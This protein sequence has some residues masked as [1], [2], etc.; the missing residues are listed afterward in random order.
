MAPVQN[1]P[2]RPNVSRMLLN[3]P[4]N[5]LISLGLQLSENLAGKMVITADG[6]TAFALSESGFLTLPLATIFQ[7]P[8][9]M[10]DTPTV[11]LANDQCG[12]VGGARAA[13]P[14][15]NIGRGRLTASA[16]LLQVPVNQ[17]GGLGAFPVPGGGPGGTIVV[18]L[19]PIVPGAGAP[20][21]VVPAPGGNGNAAVLQT[22]PQVQTQIT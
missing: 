10:P 17:V 4:D 14:V 21:G 22:A 20:P 13:V 8:I 1:P 18:V 7:S 19:P 16:Q 5:L 3:D 15:N 9:A 6:G 11:L 2:A 12:V